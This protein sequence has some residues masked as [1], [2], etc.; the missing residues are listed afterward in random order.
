MSLIRDV[1]AS[2]FGIIVIA[3]MQLF[4]I[5]T[6]APGTTLNDMAT[7]NLAVGNGSAEL[8]Y[9]AAILYC[10]VIGYV[11]LAIAPLVRVFSTDTRTAVR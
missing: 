5:E 3:T 9:K 10:P 8:M 4:V 1:V 6:V 7:G 11:T 2:A